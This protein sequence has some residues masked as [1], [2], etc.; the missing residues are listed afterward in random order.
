[1]KQSHIVK[2]VHSNS[3]TVFFGRY[4]ALLF[5]LILSAGICVALFMLLRIVNSSNPGDTAA[6][7]QRINTS[8]DETTIERL[9]ELSDDTTSSST[10]SGRVNPFV[11]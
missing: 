9:R 1:M 3:L 11:E 4:H 5:F 2:Q 10:P 6:D 8:F 7:A